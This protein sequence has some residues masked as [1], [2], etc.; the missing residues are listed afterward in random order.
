MS[1]FPL[2]F[3]K[4]AFS[5]TARKHEIQ[6][7]YCNTLATMFIAYGLGGQKGM[8]DHFTHLPD[9]GRTVLKSG[10]VCEEQINCHRIIKS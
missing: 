8:P 9:P 3:L 1:S 5:K 4:S 10:V 2:R 6:P 7:E